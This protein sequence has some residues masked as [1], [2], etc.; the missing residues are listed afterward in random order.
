MRRIADALALQFS[1]HPFGRGERATLI[2]RT[3]GPFAATGGLLDV[4]D[5]QIDYVVVAEDDV[6]MKIVRTTEDH[7]LASRPRVGAGAAG[8]TVRTPAI[9]IGEAG[10]GICDTLPHRGLARVLIGDERG[11][12]ALGC[13]I[14]R[15]L[16]RT[17]D[18]LPHVLRLIRAG[19]LTPTSR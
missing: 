9:G 13:P 17:L 19:V 2:L 11:E 10:A 14:V 5:R 12:L 1:Q 16:R 3:V 7:F 8:A 18:C 6:A 15:L 4:A